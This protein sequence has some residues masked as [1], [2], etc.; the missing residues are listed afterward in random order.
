MSQ[1][2]HREFSLDHKNVGDEKKWFS[3]EMNAIC[4]MKIDVT[5]LSR[6]IA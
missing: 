4:F 6:R 2:L 1:F 5:S 3:V